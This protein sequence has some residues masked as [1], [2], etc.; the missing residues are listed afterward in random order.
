MSG[1]AHLRIAGASTRVAP[2]SAGT[3]LDETRVSTPMAEYPRFA[4]R[5]ATWR[6][7]G[8]DLVWLHLRTDDPEVFGIGQTRGGAVTEALL[9]HHLLPL[10]DGQDPLAPAL[11][12]D[13]LRRA[14]APYA[15]GGAVEMAVAAVELA[16]WDLSARAHRVPLYRLL[17]G[18][19][20]EVPY[21]LTAAHPD[22][23][24]EVDDGLVADARCVKVPMAYGPADGPSRFQDNVERLFT[25]RARVPAHIPLAVDC[26]MSWDVPYTLRFAAATREL[27]LGWIEE[28]LHPEDVDG[29]AELRSRL[30]DGT[31][32]AA[33]EHAFGLAAGLRLL[34]ARAVDV[35]QSDVT[36]CGGIG[37]ARCLATV[38]RQQGVPFAPHAAAAQPWA[39]HLLAACEPPVLAEVLLGI[40]GA[41]SGTGPAAR[42]VV[43]T[44]PGVGIDPGDVGFSR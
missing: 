34:Q 8:A 15:A 43:G 3:W 27:G 37:V 39:L 17:G 2:F 31:R 16:L 42:P 12:A 13:Q 25:V 38:A 21:Y 36:W 44:T 5:R 1:P 19:A 24:A 29:H 6:G 22:V 4:D 7:P 10:L 11:V 30:G 9:S 41:G 26:F 40:A 18:G 33:G 35:L 32:I 20:D 28:P 23:L 14:A